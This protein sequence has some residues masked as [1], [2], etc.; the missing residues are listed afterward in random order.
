MEKFLLV[1]ITQYIYIL[2]SH[3]MLIKS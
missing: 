2:T 1:I 3:W